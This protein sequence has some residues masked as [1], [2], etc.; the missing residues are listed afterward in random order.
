MF[1]AGNYSSGSPIIEG[2][3][4]DRDGAMTLL[5]RLVGGSFPPD[6]SPPRLLVGRLPEPLPV[7]LPLPDGARVVGS[8]L[9]GRVATMILDVDS[10]AQQVLDFYRDRLLA[11]GWTEA[12]QH[13]GWHGGFTPSAHFGP[14][15]ILC[16]GPR[17]PSLSVQATDVAGAPTDVR[18]NLNIDT[19]QS[20]CAAHFRQRGVNE[21]LPNLTPPAGAQQMPRGGGG[22]GNSWHSNATLASTL[23]LAAIAAHYAHQLRAANWTP[24]GEGT[25]GPVAWSSWSFKDE[26]GEDWR[27]LLFVLRRPEAEGQ[28]VLNLRADSGP[29]DGPSGSWSSALLSS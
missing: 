5:L 25:S 28:Y 24:K 19:R 4:E 23:D 22:G 17:G 29:D 12:G 8:Q 3:D 2:A 11:A 9:R 21:V 27:G 1:Y 13:T 7:E 6:E 20:P 26:S 15:L 10:P 16:R 18:L 14:D